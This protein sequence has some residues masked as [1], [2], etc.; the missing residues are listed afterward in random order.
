MRDIERR[1]RLI[2]ARRSLRS[3]ASAEPWLVDGAVALN[4]R[5]G[6]RI[7]TAELVA[8]PLPPNC[9]RII[10]SVVEPQRSDL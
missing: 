2:E 6:E 5:T 1:L 3:P 4:R 8:R 10:R 9:L 7:T